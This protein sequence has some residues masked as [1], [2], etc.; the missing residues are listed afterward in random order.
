MP[1]YK[2]TLS[3]DVTE[4]YLRE[5]ELDM[6]D[7]KIREIRVIRENPRFRRYPE[8]KE[9][10]VEFIGS[11]PKHWDTVRCANLFELK[12]IKQTSG[13]INLSVYRDYGVIKRDSRDDNYNRVSADTSNYKLVEPG[14]FVFNKMKCWQGS[15]G[16]SEYRGIVSPA[17]T[18][19]NPKRH[20]HG[21]YFHYLLRSQPYIQEFNRLSY[22]VRIGQWELRFE[23][24]KDVTVFYPS[25]SEQ[26]QIANF[27]DHK[28]KQIDELIRIKE[29]QIELLLE[30]R[31]A[32]I[33]QAVTK[34]LGPNVEMKP[35]GVEW[36]G[37]MPAHWTP[38]MLK[39]A[40]RL[41][42]G[43]TLISE[44]RDNGVVPVYGSNGIIDTHSSANTL[45][46]AI[47]VGRKGSLGKIQ[48]SDVSCFVIDTAYYIDRRTSHVNLRWLYYILQA[49]KLER[50]RNSVLPGLN[51]ESAESQYIPLIVEEEQTQIANFLDQK[52]Q[53]I[54]EL[55]TAEQRK[56]ELLKEYRQSL[57]SEAVT[58]KIDVR[59]EV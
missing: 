44:N 45:S 4:H 53:Q 36:I 24:F 47:I 54:D 7:N 40:A 18:V 46:P 23:D 35:S 9:S 26:T 34:G 37:E 20:F 41:V 38:V 57:I 3:L 39:Y 56:I 2:L 33:N 5:R 16:V 22:G 11:I 55:I 15:L 8:Y 48:Y 27:L 12:H 10:G 29:R 32:L 50:F 58:G 17:Y 59:N 14:D 52:T 49:L 28:T 21:K 31:T 43:D 13:E 51:R 19:C 25:L 30:Q 6:A 1:Y 42:Y